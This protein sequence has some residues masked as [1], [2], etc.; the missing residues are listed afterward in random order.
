VPAAELRAEN[1]AIV[2]DATKRHATYGSLADKAAKQKPPEKP[3]TKADDK[4]ALIG[5]PTKRIDATAKVKGEAT[6]G[7][8]VQIPGMLIARVIHSPVFGGTVKSFDAK[9]A[10]KVH[11]VKDVVQIP[12]GVAVVADNFWSAKTGADQVDVTWDDGGNKSLS[13]ESITALFKSILDKGV[14]AKKEGD[15]G[16][17]IA[18][19]AKKI[20]AVY[21]VPYLAHATMEPVNATADVRADRC[22]IWAP[23]QGQMLVHQA[24]AQVTGLPIEKV[25]VHTTFLGGGFGR[26]ANADFVLDAVHLSKAI[27]KPVKVIWAR[28]DDMRGGWYRPA[29]YNALSASLDAQGV[30]NAWVHRIA[31]PSIM[32]KLKAFGP[33]KDGIDQ[34]AVEGAA[35]IP[36]AIPNQHVT[37]AK[38]DLPI[39]V[40]FWRSVGS[41]INAFVTECFLDELAAL[42]G[43]DP[44]E[45]RR[46]LLTKAPRHKRVLEKVAE[47]SG[48]KKPPAKGRGRG[49]AVHESFGSI[50]AQVAEVSVADGGK[51]RVHK[52]W[53]AI[54]CG[55]V[56]NPSTIK[57]QMESGIVYGLSAALYGKIDIAE[58]RAVQGNF[59]TY[60]VIRMAEMPEVE[61]EVVATGD[62]W[63]GVGEP[64]TPPI[65]PAVANA[66]FALTKKPVRRL[67]ICPGMA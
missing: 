42:G 8:D 29:A 50:V 39:S 27:K 43:K 40:W 20:E 1:G 16:A 6:F 22:E 61:V 7:I 66:I 17:T 35:D 14:D 12:T 55:R 5:K 33:L 2:H 11:G 32:E 36:Y 65:A 58:G 53:C 41:S 57:A 62:P 64:G 45:L 24:A 19:S 48:W 25:T 46:T 3:E 63:G 34:T 9:E 21:E 31:S 56:V 37:W 10:K 30:P 44:F 13:N 18:K 60:S 4:L 23:T 67:P 47:M 52:V 15:A 51:V 54:D 59:D 26:K 49:I 28:E 38:A